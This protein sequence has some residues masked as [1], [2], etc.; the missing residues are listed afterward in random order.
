MD[1]ADNVG[2]NRGG[3]ADIDRVLARWAAAFISHCPDIGSDP[4]VRAFDLGAAATDETPAICPTAPLRLARMV[5]FLGNPRNRGVA[6]RL[7]LLATTMGLA[8]AAAAPVAMR[9]GGLVGIEA[10]ATAALLCFGGAI[11][12]L[13]VVDRLRTPNG[14]LMGLWIGLM[15]RTV[16]PFVAGMAIHLHGG[17][18]AQAGLVWYL[19]AFYPIA[20]AVGTILSLLPTKQRPTPTR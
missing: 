20:I 19:L 7:G 3:R 5:A 2:F 9:R 10:A 15:L 11:L 14:A 4:R 6:A 8:L 18:L 17:P 1:G 13:I 16:A 12:A